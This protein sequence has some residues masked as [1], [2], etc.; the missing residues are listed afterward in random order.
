MEWPLWRPDSARYSENKNAG[1]GDPF[2]A[3]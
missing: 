3:F 2:P 1:N